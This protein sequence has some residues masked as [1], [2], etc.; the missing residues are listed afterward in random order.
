MVAY[1]WLLSLACAL[2]LAAAGS[3][4]PRA[5]AASV[6]P[7]D[8]RKVFG[9]FLTKESKIWVPFDN[10]TDELMQRWS[11]YRQPHYLGAIKPATE[12]DVEKIVQIAAKNKIPFLATGGGH[13]LSV[14]LERLHDGIDVDLGNFK[15]VKLDKKKNTLTLGGSVEFL[16]FVDL[17]YQ[18][19]KELTVG[20]AQC[21]GAL[22]FA[23]GG[24]QGTLL[25]LRGPLSDSLLS[26]R[27]VTGKGKLVTASATENPDLF[28]AVRGAGHNFGIVTEAK[29]R[30]YDA[31]N[32]GQ[33][34][35]ADFLF[36]PEKNGSVYEL[37][38]TLDE[39]MPAAMGMNVVG[40]KGRGL[41]PG[42]E[43]IFV[44]VNIQYYGPLAQTQPFIDS[45]RALGPLQENITVVGWDKIFEAA[46]M[47]AVHQSSCTRGNIV[48]SYS[49]AIKKHHVPTWIDRFNVLAQM[50][51]TYPEYSGQLMIHR[52]S[53]IQAL[54]TPDWATAFPLREAIAHV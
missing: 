16:D 6:K 7:V 47:G 49:V 23:L 24:G 25:G 54:K 41:F 9:P 26:V 50:Y 8:I 33:V 48:N 28:W 18:N 10:T 43:G 22:G 12:K 38:A 36:A 29:F 13:S 11:V 14:A 34:V 42:V 3:F 20:N 52:T 32:D 21:V 51:E 15:T 4:Y 27:I 53:P 44:G 5:D 30:V 39:T 45:Y 19:G 17:L 2:P 35:N 46:W 31:T 40:T 37:L 1:S